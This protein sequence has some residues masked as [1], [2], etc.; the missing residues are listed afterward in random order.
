MPASKVIPQRPV[1]ELEV[2]QQIK[3]AALWHCAHTLVNMAWHG[4]AKGGEKEESK[5]RRE[6]ESE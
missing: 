4:M 1:L 5:K 3:T 6:G 2:N